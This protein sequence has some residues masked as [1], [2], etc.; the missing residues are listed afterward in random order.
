M[1][2]VMYKEG[3]RKSDSGA[4]GCHNRHKRHVARGCAN[5]APAAATHRRAPVPIHF[6]NIIFSKTFTFHTTYTA[7]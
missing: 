2:K 6:D 3:A 7:L 1:K 4:E 5:C